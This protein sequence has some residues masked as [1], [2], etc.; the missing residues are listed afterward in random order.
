MMI[1]HLKWKKKGS[2]VY[3]VTDKWR[4]HVLQIIPSRLYFDR[5]LIHDLI[6]EILNVDKAQE[7]SRN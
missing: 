1:K 6:A 7:T 2:T 3:R 4:E 5:I